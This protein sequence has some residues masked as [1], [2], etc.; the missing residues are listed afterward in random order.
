MDIMKERIKFIELNN[1]L[2]YML[3]TRS[4]EEILELVEETLD[5]IN[6]FKE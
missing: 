2:A 6:L 1:I 5:I 3:E 4:K